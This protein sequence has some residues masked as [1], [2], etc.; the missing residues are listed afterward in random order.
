MSRR[1]GS[2]K[3]TPTPLTACLWSQKHAKKSSCRKRRPY[4]KANAT[5]QKPAAYR[6]C[7]GGG[8]KGSTA[9]Q[10]QKGYY[11]EASPRRY[12]GEHRRYHKGEVMRK[13]SRRPSACRGVRRGNQFRPADDAICKVIGCGHRVPPAGLPI[14]QVLGEYSLSLPS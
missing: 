6:R 1:R 4:N 12:G 13:T 14:E 10:P 5:H 11:G 7:S 8:R 9:N 2:S 3:P